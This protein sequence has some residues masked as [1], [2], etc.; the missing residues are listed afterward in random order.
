MLYDIELRIT[1]LYVASAAGARQVARLMP[2]TMPDEQDVVLAKLDV[3]PFP[4]ERYERPD[5]FGNLVTEVA[6][7]AA[8][9]K[10]E[11]HLHARVRR[12][13]KPPTLL[14][15]PGPIALAAE[16]AKVRSL[17]A[18]SP[19][20]F[21][22]PSPRVPVV[23]QLVDYSRTVIARARPTLEAVEAIG[24]ALHRDLAFDPKATKVDTPMADAFAARHGVCQDFTH[25]M[26]GALR[27][28][29]VPAGYVSG[30][31]RTIPP[32]GQER[33]QGA[34]AMH[35]WVRA[36]CG[37]EL[38]W[39]EYDPTNACFAGTD[40]VVIARGRDYTDVAPVKGVLRTAG[41]QAADH[42]VD[43]VEVDG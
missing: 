12:L 24:L 22:A 28:L 16:M 11:F 9:E 40:H 8:Q 18:D 43:V 31:L 15:S 34:D 37:P 4:D 5:F 36:W 17:A 13:A 26:I 32:E 14:P 21:L 42:A 41:M 30:F 25:I 35:A 38:G 19:H 1:Q 29:G 33:L 27:S 10:I 6:Y 3:S 23:T 2:R 7:K 39:V 20:H